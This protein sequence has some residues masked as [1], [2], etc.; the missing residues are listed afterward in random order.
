MPTSN[1][2]AWLKN[3]IERGYFD[4]PGH[5]PKS[6]SRRR[7]VDLFISS[8]FHDEDD[9]ERSVSTSIG[10]AISGQLK[11]KVRRAVRGGARVR[12]VIIPPLEHCRNALKER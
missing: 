4:T 6:I 3:I 11:W 12:L 9:S 7:L 10:I 2:L 1:A 5:W 8:P